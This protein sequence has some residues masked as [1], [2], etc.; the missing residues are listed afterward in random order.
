DMI[1]C[2]EV[3]GENAYG[4]ARLYAERFPNRRDPSRFTILR[5]MQRGRESG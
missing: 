2:Y 5:C 3:A 1:V 4:A